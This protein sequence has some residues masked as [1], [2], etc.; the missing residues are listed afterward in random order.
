MNQ[1]TEEYLKEKI[2]PELEK[3]RPGWD[4]PHTEAVVS[5]MKEIIKQVPQLEPVKE[6]LIIA[7][8]AHDWGY[9]GLFQ[10]GKP[11][12]LKK[13]MESKKLHMIIGAEKIGKLLEDD[14]FNYLTNE[15]K[16]RTIHLVRVHDKLD[17]S[18]KD[19]DELAL[20]EADTL[21][22]ID[23]EKVKPTFDKEDNEKWMKIC[24][25]RRERISRFINPY[26]KEKIEKLFKKR[27]E[28]FQN[29]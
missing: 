15:Q 10:D 12:D 28:Y 21:G 11:V 19:I 27:E 1:Q 3:G 6:I 17:G 26:S 29:I 13:I 20:L 5:Y 16:Q 2:F 7:A 22:M 25:C 4:K 8:Y 14:V 9:A 24:I 18:L 23:V